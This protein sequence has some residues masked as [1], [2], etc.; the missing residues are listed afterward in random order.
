[1]CEGG[2]TRFCGR[3]AEAYVGLD[4]LPPLDLDPLAGDEEDA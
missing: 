1:M 2:F 4:D 3:E